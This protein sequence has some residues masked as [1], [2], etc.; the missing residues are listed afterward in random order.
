[1]A[2]MN[3]PAGTDFA[4]AATAACTSLMEAA[5]SRR[6]SYPGPHAEQHDVIVIVDQAGNSSAAAQ[7][8]G[9]SARAELCAGE[10]E[11]PILDG[12]RR[13]NRCAHPR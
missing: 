2:V 10:I 5:V 8:D 1:M 11:A 12:D 3:L 4:R 6:V 7:V 13:Q 9:L